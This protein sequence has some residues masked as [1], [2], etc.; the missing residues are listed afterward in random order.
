MFHRL[1]RTS[2]HIFPFW[3][4]QLLARAMGRLGLARLLGSLHLLGR[5]IRLLQILVLALVLALALAL[6]LGLGLGPEHNLPE[7]PTLRSMSCFQ[8]RLSVPIS[9]FHLLFS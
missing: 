6:A 5:P 4:N 1:G 7:T 8:L 2:R 3:G 9:M